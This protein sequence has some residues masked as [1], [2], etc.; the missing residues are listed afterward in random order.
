MAGVLPIYNGTA[1]ITPAPSKIALNTN[2]IDFATAGA[3]DGWAQQ[4]LP[5][6]MAQEAEVYGNRTISGFLAQVGA[7]EAM[8]SD[9]VVWS[10]QGRL[11]ITKTSTAYTTAGATENNINFA[12]AHSFK[13]N[14]TVMVYGLTGNA[15]G[16]GKTVKCLVTAVATT[17]QITVFPY[18]KAK[19]NTAG[20]MQAT[21]GDTFQ[22]LTYGS[23]LPKGS[24]Y[25]RN[26]I[27]PGFKSHT[28]KP[29]ILRDKYEVSG[30]DTAQIGWV[31]ISGEEG[32]SGYMWYIKAEAETR[33]RFADYLEMAMIEGEKAVGTA[34]G[35]IAALNADAG[36][37]G[38]FSA[39]RTRGNV[40][41]G[42]FASVTTAADNLLTFDLILKKFDAQGA[43]EEN[44]LF[45]NRDYS[46]KFDDM[47]AAVGSPNGSGYGLFNN[48]A[49][50]ALNLGF[51]GFRRGSYDFYKSDWKYLND[52][53]TRGTVNDISG[54][55]IPAGTSNV[56]DQQLGKNIRRPFLH[57]RYRASQADNRKMK[58]WVTGSVGAATSDLDAMEVN[59]LSERCLVTQGAMNFMLMNTLA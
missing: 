16:L 50:M 10:E 39:I 51:T 6:L 32:Q 57:V 34:A 15:A 8:E 11:H 31:E 17:T 48:S 46:L 4:Y 12:T 28:N 29:I 44:M 58:T 53:S 20:G 22:V 25:D 41:N 37:E 24:T 56:Y 49:D 18:T 54:V 13:V 26:A 19:L 5:E 40:L 45:L 7:E 9:Q 52:V 55:I 2:Y 33:T 30:S 3:S 36:T 27:E 59:Y 14:D 1:T 35:V 23:E 21:V 43:I 42:G 38:L 47:L